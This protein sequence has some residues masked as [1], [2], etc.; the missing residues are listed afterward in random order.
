EGLGYIDPS[1]QGCTAS[2]TGLHEDTTSD[3]GVQFTSKVWREFLDKL[4]IMCIPVSGKAKGSG[5]RP[6]AT[7]ALTSQPSD[8]KWIDD[9][10]TPPACWET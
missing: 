4:N 8:G 9:G 5:R 1:T 3:R 10:E 7:S 6:I 2:Q